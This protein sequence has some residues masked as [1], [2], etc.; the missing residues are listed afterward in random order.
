VRK[1]PS[2]RVLQE[3]FDYDQST[4]IFHWIKEPRVIGPRLGLVAGTKR[5]TGYVMISVPGYGQLGAHRLAWIFVHGTTVGGAEIDHI[6]GNPSNN[7]ISNLRLA[8]SS[9]QKRNRRVQSNNRSGL[10]GAF[11]H[12]GRKGKKWRTQI[13]VGADLIFLG[14]F[15]TAEEAHRAYAEAA[16]EHF[17]EYARVA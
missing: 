14:Y 11:Y 7:A 13:K 12:A 9:E 4:G 3:W 17:G 15:H 6:D 1:L 5:R 16:V 2:Q 10:K 8:T